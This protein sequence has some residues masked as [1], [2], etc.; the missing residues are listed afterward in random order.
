MSDINRLIQRW[1]AGDERAAEAIY[2]QYRGLTFGLAFALL[3]NSADA[4]EVT[5][6]SLTYALTNIGRY[7]A[8]QARFFTWLHTITVSRCRNKRRRRYLPSISLFAWLKKG[9]DITD[10]TPTPEHQA[11]DGA[12][13][14]EAW[15][16]IQT[17]KPHHREAVVLRYW[18]DFTYQEMAEILGCSARAARSRLQSAHKQL[19]PILAQN[20]LINLEET[21]Q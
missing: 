15:Q 6:D 3:S 21:I 8:Q 19:G 17:L 9:R 13:R 1:Q 18:A 10:P 11:L 5:Q 12:L 7:D 20:E 16:A 14:D 2:N 4:E